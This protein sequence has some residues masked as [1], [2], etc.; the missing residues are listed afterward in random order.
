MI[1]LENTIP[2]LI[3]QYD[4]L[5]V[6]RK[7]ITQDDLDT[8]INSV[9]EMNFTEGKYNLY[10]QQSLSKICN[11][12]YAVS[13]NSGS[14]ANWLAITALRKRYENI[15]DGDEIITVACG[16]P[17]TI[18]PI[19]QN[20]LIPVFIDMN[21]KSLNIDC[22]IIKNAIGPKTKAIFVA[23]TLG[24]PIN[25]K[26]ISKISKRYNLH[27]LFDCCDALGSNYNNVPIGKY[28]IMSTFSFYPAHQITAG[29]G[30]AIV[31]DDPKLYKLLN[32]LKSW[33]KSCFCL[34]GQDNA[35][36]HRFD[37]QF[38]D[39][40]NGYD[41]KYVYSE[42][43]MNLKITDM[44]AA[45]G[46]SQLKKLPNFKKARQMN[47][48]L[49][50]NKMK[51]LNSL[52]IQTD[53]LDESDVCWFGYPVIFKSNNNNINDLIKYLE[54][55][56]KIGTRRLFAGNLLKHPAYKKLAQGSYRVYGNLKVT[57]KIMNNVFWLGVHPSLNEDCMEY[58][59]K[60]VYNFYK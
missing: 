37:Q 10:F 60:S 50:S 45:L 39:L 49:L 59:F 25:I 34:P 14:S 5:P 23:H 35:C 19:I 48:N 52:F 18:N 43:G 1:E 55:N 42:I 28:G 21:Y 20:N 41:H 32:S 33:G 53:F 40:P 51:I 38:G 17:T 6:S 36:G 58:I 11:R 29:E 2:D 7:F 8:M 30:G 22:N 26:E 56:C 16:F 12:K 13:C 4:Y 15:Q 44:Q 54:N 46:F 57:D 9:L 31:T 24:N 47:Y 3:P 27:L